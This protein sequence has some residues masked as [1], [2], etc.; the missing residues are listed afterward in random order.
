MLAV[1]KQYASHA[2]QQFWMGHSGDIEAAYTVNKHSLP[3]DLIEDMRKSYEKVANQLL[4]TRSPKGPAA[5]DIKRMHQESLLLLSGY[6][7]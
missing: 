1:N 2:Y 5:E 7:K 4:Q 6:K 3:E